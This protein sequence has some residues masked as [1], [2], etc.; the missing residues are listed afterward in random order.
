MIVTDEPGFYQQ[1]Q[2][3]IRIENA[4]VIRETASMEH[5]HFQNLTLSP[6]DRN[7]MDLSLMTP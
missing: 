4:L 3:G 7:L 6:Y 2:F 5:L 1:G